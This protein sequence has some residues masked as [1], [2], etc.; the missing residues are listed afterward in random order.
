MQKQRNLYVFVCVDDSKNSL[1]VRQMQIHKGD[2]NFKLLTPMQFQSLPIERTYLQRR[3]YTH[4]FKQLPAALILKNGQFH[5][6]IHCS[7]LRF[8]AK[9]CDQCALGSPRNN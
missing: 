1:N 5:K 7:V 3:F 4:R 8:V 9:L 2:Y 6:T